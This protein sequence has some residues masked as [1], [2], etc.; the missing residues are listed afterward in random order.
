MKSIVILLL[1][2][3][4]AGADSV[5]NRPAQWAVRVEKPGLP[6]FHKV[7][8]TLYRGA[9]PDR[10]GFRQLK[11][12]GIKTIVNLRSFH[13]DRDE[14]GDLQFVREHI[15][16][17]AWHAEDKEIVRFLKIATNTNGTP[18]FVHCQH[19][20]DRTG[21]MCA[22]YRMAVQGWPKDAAITEMTDGGYGYHTVWKNLIAFL[23]D[24]DMDKLRQ[25]AGLPA[26]QR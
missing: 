26:P 16:F 11:A 24:L 10:E 2:V 22:V 23:R 1:F 4:A 3:S 8:D 19:G 7:A 9:Q 5:T 17:K 15:W 13:S 20:A 6:N 18:V 25:A 21:T 14:I 12:M